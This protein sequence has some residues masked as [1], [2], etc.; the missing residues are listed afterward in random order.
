MA[1]STAYV[2]A[3]VFAAA[4]VVVLF[5]AGMT[6]KTRLRGGFG[7]LILERNDLRGIAFFYVGLAG[8]V[9]GLTTGNFAFPTANR[10]KVGVRSMRVGFELIFVAVL[11]G[12]AADVVPGGCGG[13]RLCLNRLDCL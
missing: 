13:N 5:P 8:T 12:F 4:E 2:V 9:T 7:G 10:G 3:P 11:A 1:V 6:G